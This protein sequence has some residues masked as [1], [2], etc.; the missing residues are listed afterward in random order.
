MPLKELALILLLGGSPLIGQESPPSAKGGP[1]EAKP[2][3]YFDFVGGTLGDFA[4]SIEKQ[5]GFNLRQEASVPPHAWNLRVPKLKIYHRNGKDAW[6]DAVITYNNISR[7]AEGSL[8]EWILHTQPVGE[9]T[10]YTAIMFRPPPM[11]ALESTVKAFHIGALRGDDKELLLRTVQEQ[12]A[13]LQAADPAEMEAMEGRLT[14]D[15]GADILIAKGGPQFMQLV[16]TLVDAFKE[17]QAER[18]LAEAY[19]KEAER[20]EVE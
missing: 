19:K 14:F 8:G 9:K 10:H 1:E 17:R 20:K 15:R 11:H 16:T 3:P 7:R 18:N 12:Q 6:V 13:R 4:T 2:L 5:L